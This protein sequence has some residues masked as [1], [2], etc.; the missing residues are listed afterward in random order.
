MSSLFENKINFCYADYSFLDEDKDLYDFG[1]NEFNSS[2]KP[3]SSEERI[4]RAF[5]YRSAT[6]LDGFIVTAN[7]STYFGGGYVYEMRGSR[8][9]IIANISLLQK[10]DWIDRQTRAIFIE[11]TTYNPNIDMFS[12]STIIFEFLPSGNILKSYKFMPLNLF[13]D[14]REDV[15]VFKM[16]FYFIYLIYIIF[17]IVR[18]LKLIY[19]RKE[20]YILNVWSWNEWLIIGFSLA[21][22][23]FTI[24][25]IQKAYQIM[26]FFKKNGGYGY[27]KLQYA[28]IWNEKLDICLAFCC[29]FG[30]LKFFKLLRFYPRIGLLV[31]TLR[32]C[33]RELFS[34]SVVFLIVW[35]SF[36]QCFYIL[37]N[38]RLESFSSFLNSLT[39]CFQIIMGK[40]DSN[41]ITNDKLSSVIYVMYHVVIL[42]FLLNIFVA[43]IIEAFDT[44][45][46]DPLCA[47][48]EHF[49]MK[50]F[51]Q[52]L[53]GLF[54]K[55]KIK[56]MPEQKAAGQ[57]SAPL[58]HLK[59]TTD[60]LAKFVTNVIYIFFFIIMSFKIF[61]V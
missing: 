60:T 19:K 11:F 3:D 55:K 15:I 34:F 1:W 47:I 46:K 49:L 9:Q 13:G 54:S 59:A 53:F 27:I 12:Y 41:S 22:F 24:Y 56:D 36:V 51:K 58:D 37:L 30:T 50:L 18:E 10:L 21:S 31:D 43:I 45:R 16:I 26:D 7:Y 52:K 40:F 28:S 29:F 14:I 35:I 48:S 32:G 5:Q 20:Q 33:A 6:D 17:C 25:R 23:V 61:A 42:F 44:A 2:Y 57:T 8:S 4:Y 39:T 38:E